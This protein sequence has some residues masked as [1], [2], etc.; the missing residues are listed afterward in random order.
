MSDAADDLLRAVARLMADGQRVLLVGASFETIELL[1]DAPL[2]ELVIVSDD[3]DPDAPAGET[4]RGAPLRLRPDWKER[5]RS[6]DL[7]V[8][9]AGAAPVEEVE[10][11]LKK[12]GVYLSAVPSPVLDALPFS[13]AVE[14]GETGALVLAPTEGPS[15]LIEAL[16]F[17]GERR[18]GPL[19][20]VAGR[21]AVALPAVAVLRGAGPDPAASAAAAA[22]ADEAERALADAQTA[23]AETHARLDA[24]IAEAAAAKHR[25]EAAEAQ[26][27]DRAALEAALA[28]AHRERDEGRAALTARDAELA[29]LEADYEKVRTELAERRFDDRRF[30]SLRAR[31]ESARAEMADEVA[32]LRARL[33]EVDAPAED[34]AA[35]VASRD[36]ARSDVQRLLAR[37]A[38]TLARL[39]PARRLPATPVHAD[40]D[41]AGASI[42]A[43]LEV[44]ETVV[45]ATA[46]ELAELRDEQAGYADHLGELVARI[47]EQHAAIEALTA[48]AAEAPAA[49]VPTA[50]DDEAAA[51]LA[52]LEGALQSER[53]LRAAE[54]AERL[55]AIEA[56]QAAEREGAALKRRVVDER[57]AAAA[58]RLAAAA[59]E[60]EAERLAVELRRRATQAGDLEEMI[61]AHDRMEALLTEA[62][63]VAEE[64]AETAETARRLAES[65]LRLLRG[66]F[67][68]LRPGP[69]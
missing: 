23:I 28:V 48:E 4:A 8:D 69:G 39:A 40:S 9:P 7:I 68:R 38:D 36:R 31:F 58:A 42:D 44:V 34:F 35:L 37:L 47:R 45:D 1:A 29:E 10:R 3:A 41:A 43:W 13:G 2:R 12:E 18:P 65:N 11:I 52:A 15:E 5:A 46:T 49:P 60:D 33:L 21:E 6:K 16:L 62:L 67:E 27:A 56:A 50:S 55:R 53:A 24:A 61:T 51:R 59:A 63:Q 57:R 17:A 14:A 26:V 25:A 66:E 30:E 54:R 20:Y 19:L 32:R 22:R 64:R